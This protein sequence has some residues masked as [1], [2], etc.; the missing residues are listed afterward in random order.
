MGL[1]IQTLCVRESH[2]PARL[3]SLNFHQVVPNLVFKNVGIVCRVCRTFEV[4]DN[5]DL[6]LAQFVELRVSLNVISC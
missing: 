6:D 5:S 3:G 1:G 2:S 4:F